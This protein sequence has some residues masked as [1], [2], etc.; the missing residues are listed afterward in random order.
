MSFLA[1]V[2]ISVAITAVRPYFGAI[3]G[4]IRDVSNRPITNVTVYL[5]ND[6]ITTFE[7]AEAAGLY[8]AGLCASKSSRTA[9]S[10][11]VEVHYVL[12]NVPTGMYT[13]N[14]RAV[15]D[16]R[17]VVSGRALYVAVAPSIITTANMVLGPARPLAPAGGHQSKNKV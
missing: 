1:I 8:A 2:S 4:N 9:G 15:R 11:P 3:E 14:A 16:D 12:N 13:V 17:A 5:T 7:K 10:A 6:T